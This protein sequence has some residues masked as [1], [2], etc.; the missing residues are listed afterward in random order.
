MP[1]N[2][3]QIRNL[4]ERWAEAVHRGD[5]AGVLTDHAEDIVMFDVPP[6]YEGVRGLD[7]YRKTWL[8]FFQWQAQGASFEIESLDI[9]ASD[10]VAFAYALLRCGTQDDFADHPDN[11]LRLT[12]G[13]HKQNGRWIVTHEH[14]SFPLI[15]SATAADSR[16]TDVASEQDVR[17]LHQRWFDSTAAKDLDGLMAAIADDVVSYEHEQPLQYVGRQAVR[18]ICKAGLDASSDGTVTWGVPDL[19]ILVDGDL[20]VAW[21]LNHIRIQSIEGQVIDSW[22]RG[23]R[24]FQRRNGA[25]LMV[26]QHLSYPYDPSKSAAKTD[27]HP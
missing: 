24:V 21:G 8:P 14:H 26:H 15:D 10:D 18:E 17:Q 16:K 19:E 22:S 13:L 9:T 1:D 7:A 4:I 23:T 6:P 5:L 12:L 20:G 11:R 2:E 3:E 27:L 25:W